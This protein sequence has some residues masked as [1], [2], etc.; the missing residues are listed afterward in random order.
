M[1]RSFSLLVALV[2][3]QACTT[4]PGSRGPKADPG[5]PPP[6][7]LTPAA[8]AAPVGKTDAGI[9]KIYRSSLPICFDGALKVFRERD[10][11]VR[12]Q[13]RT[14]QGATISA[15]ARGL[16]CTMTLAADGSRTRVLARVQG[17]GAPENRD[18]AIS[19]LN[20]LSDTL[21]EPR[22]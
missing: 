21:L 16:D 15:H 10:Y 2:L 8:A 20:K 13:D 14:P 19:L 5:P 22:D 7:Q 1:R 18:E 9:E 11:H 4:G 6:E 3:L 12:R 17:R